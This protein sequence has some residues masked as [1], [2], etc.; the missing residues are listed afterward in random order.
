MLRAVMR[1]LASIDAADM[2]NDLLEFRFGLTGVNIDRREL[3]Q[4]VETVLRAEIGQILVN[5]SRLSD[6][7]VRGMS[8]RIVAQILPTRDNVVP[9]AVTNRAPERLR[10]E[11]MEALIRRESMRIGEPRDK[12]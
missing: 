7:A 8:R 5:H 6:Q 4:R 12:K 2:V 3:D 11:D 1:A 10:V 9:A